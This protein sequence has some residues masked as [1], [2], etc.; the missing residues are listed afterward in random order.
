MKTLLL[1][2][3]LGAGLAAAPAFADNSTTAQA[4]LSAAPQQVA[5]V[6]WDDGYRHH[7][8]DRDHWDRDHWRHRRWRHHRWEWDD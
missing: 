6:Y 4:N 1:S 5:Q 7:Y 3:L 8:Y 2:A